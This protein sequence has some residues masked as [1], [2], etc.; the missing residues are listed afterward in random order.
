MAREP[1]R[2]DGARAQR[3][4]HRTLRCGRN[5]KL[6]IARYAMPRLRAPNCIS[7]RPASFS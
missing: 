3:S 4:E 5:G 7:S 6:T 1:G 2:T